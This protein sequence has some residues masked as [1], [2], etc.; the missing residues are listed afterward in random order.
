MDCAVPYQ[1]LRA[2]VVRCTLPL[3]V[4][5]LIV[6]SIVAFPLLMM[7]AIVG[8]PFAVLFAPISDRRK[9]RKIRQFEENC[10]LLG[11][12]CQMKKNGYTVGVRRT[13][14]RGWIS[15]VEIEMEFVVVYGASRQSTQARVSADDRVN[16]WVRQVD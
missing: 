8:T 9:A 7:V 6:F 10:A 15:S 16:G 14:S 2:F 4:P 1:R 12:Q 5:A 11:W 3:S 13:A